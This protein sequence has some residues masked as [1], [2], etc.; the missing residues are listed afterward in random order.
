[1]ME[2]GEQPEMMQGQELPPEMMAQN[3]MGSADMSGYNCLTY[4]KVMR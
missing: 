2:Q 1:M 4:N 3:D